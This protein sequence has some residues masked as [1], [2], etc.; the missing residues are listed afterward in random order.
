MKIALP[1]CLLLFGGCLSSIAAAADSKTSSSCVGTY[2]LTDGRDVDVAVSDDTHYR[3]RMKDGTTG[4]LARVSGDTWS[5]TLGWTEREDGHRVAFTD[6]AGG[7]IKFDQ[8]AGR[9]LHFDVHDT[10]FAVSG[11]NLAGRL[12]MPPGTGKV[13]IVVLL[14]GAE[15][16]SARDRYALQRLFPSVGIGTFVYDKRGTG[17][18]SGRYTQN[19]LTLAND[20]IAALHEARRLAGSRAGRVGYQAGSQGGWVAPLA[21]TIEPVDFVIVSFGLAVPPIEEDRAAIALDMSRRGYGPDVLKKAMEVADA[22]SE[23]LLSNFREGYD[24]VALVKQRYGAEPWFEFV[25]GNVS[26]FV[27]QK[28]EAELRDV[29]PTL[30]PG[31]PMEYDPMPVLRNLQT[32]QLWILGEED[33]DAPSAETVK[34]LRAL[35]NAGSPISVAVFPRA[36]HG[37][38]EFEIAPDGTRLS[39]RQPAGYFDMMRDFINGDFNSGDFKGRYGSADLGGPSL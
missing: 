38:Y 30:F 21:A 12:V 11:A 29:G 37:M 20:A 7:Q 35:V 13:P 28:P 16:D 22:T 5:S 39:T 10:R 34:R 32:R 15:H 26:F 19:F 4:K 23:V 9:M 36:E 2:R 14:H 27:L 6:C 3:W 33:I 25:H 24:Q 17:E 31:A 1:L 18:S 8:V